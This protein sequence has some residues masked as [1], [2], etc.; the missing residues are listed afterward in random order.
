MNKARPA[1]S[2]ARAPVWIWWLVGAGVL[3]FVVPLVAIF[4]ISIFGTKVGGMFGTSAAVL[5]GAHSTDNGPIA[6]GRLTP[7]PNVDGVEVMIEPSEEPYD[8]EP[9]EMPFV[10]AFHTFARAHAGAAPRTL[11]E[12]LGVRDADGVVWI[13]DASE[14]LDLWGTPYEYTRRET[15]AGWSVSLKTLGRDRR[16]GGEA[17]DADL[18]VLELVLPR[19]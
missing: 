12:L 18:V 7:T 1:N 13:G 11:D 5:P 15:S 16:A 10:R 19:E 9:A 17:L 3:L 2:S 8:S 14:F 6:V 4:A